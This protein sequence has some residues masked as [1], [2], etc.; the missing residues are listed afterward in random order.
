MPLVPPIPG[1]GKHYAE[2]GVMATIRVITGDI[3]ALPVD[4]I[5]N[6]ANSSLLGGGGVDGAIHRA[7]GPAL[8]EECRRIPDGPKGR[9]PT[10]EARITGA[11]NLPCKRVIHTV[12]PV[13]S[14]G[15]A[16]EPALL[17]ACYQNALALAEKEGLSS[18]AFPCISTGVYGYPLPEAAKIAVSTVKTR[19]PH[20][21]SVKEITFCCFGHTNNAL[22][23]KLLE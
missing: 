6:A 22:Y 5:V 14:G 19:E 15:G 21:K 16:G 17:A 18:I 20:L 2:G 11:G 4:A 13:W 3:T 12:G 9:C 23:Q 1:K 7:A 10:G 8:L